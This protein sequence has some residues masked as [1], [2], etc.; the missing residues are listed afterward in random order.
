MKQCILPL[1]A[2]AVAASTAAFAADYY[3]ALTGDD[4]NND[5]LS[6]EAPFATIDKAVSTA[7]AGDNIYVAAGEYTTS[8]ANG[9][10]LKANL[11]GLGET[12]DEVIIRAGSSARTLKMESGSLA[13]NITFIGN[14][15]SVVS[16]GGTIYMAGGTLVDCVVR[17]GISTYSSARSGGNV[18]MLNGIIDNCVISNGTAASRGGNI[19]IEGGIVRNSLISD[20]QTTAWGGNIYIKGSSAIITNCIVTGGNAQQNSNNNSYGGN[21]RVE[22]SG[23]IASCTISNGTAQDCGGNVY[24]HGS[25]TIMKDCTI[26][27]GM[28]RSTADNRF[29]ANVYVANSAQMSRCAIYGGSIGAYKGSSVCLSGG[30]MEDCLVTGCA[31]GGVLLY[32][33]NQG[34]YSCTIVANDEY[35]VWAWNAT[36]L[37]ADT[38]IYGNST[39]EWDGNMPTGGTFLNCASSSGSRLVN[40]MSSPTLVTIDDTAFTDFSG[41]D[42]TSAANGALVDAGATDP[43]GATASVTDLA[44]NPR[45]SGAIDIGCYEYQKPDMTIR[46]EGATYSQSYAPTTVTF[47]HVV[48]NSASPEN[49][50][51]IYD[52]GDDSVMQSTSEATISH[53]YAAPG[54]YTITITATNKCEEEHAEMTYDGYARVASSTIYVTPGNSSGQAFPY[55][56]PATGYAS[57]KTAVQAATNGVT[58]LLGEGVHT[59]ADQV[60]VN[61]PITIRGLGA[62]PEDVIVRNTTTSTNTYYY[63]VMDVADAGAFIENITLENGRVKNTYGG[64]LSLTAGIVSNCVIRGGLAV[65]DGGN[66]AGG[67]VVLSGAGTLTHCVVTNNEV[68][69][70]SNYDGYAG[71]AVFIEN[72]KKNGRI[73]NC[74]IA[75]NTYTPSEGDAKA[76]AAGV[77]FGGSNDN[78]AMENCSVVANKVEGSLKDD[79]AGI[80]CTT[81]YGKLRNNIVVGNYETGKDRCTSVKLD[82]NSSNNYIYHNNIT[83]DAL[84]AESGDKSKDNIL[85][86]NPSALFSDFANGGFTLNA[87]SVAYNKGTKSGLALLPSV[88]LAGNPRVAFDK[89]DIGCYERQSK[90]VTMIIML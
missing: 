67:G 50:V 31:K 90:P 47:S 24:L 11:I 23:T 62:T 37:F 48:E 33:S 7:V 9:P 1:A 21:I 13:T 45:T 52:F 59:T 55:N 60:Y 28:V 10:D 4:T 81:W 75:N 64:N 8:T 79:S 72:G 34:V 78:V 54:I 44:G 40:D 43:R 82:F 87:S 32:S 26:S 57:L 27:G 84:I 19:D 76:G 17:D 56:T 74:L 68:V 22:N 39:A 42:Y 73:S 86:Q 77:R 88:D 83:D 71:G 36:Q 46:L 65:A 49:V 14:T 3:V 18:M 38:V 80:Y 61:K 69:G 89:I 16:Q 35:G 53:E 5:G 85:V 2:F 58:L 29:G 63:R 25:G 41:G 70:T 30:T 6:A 20:G 12:R 66:A 51:F 15:E